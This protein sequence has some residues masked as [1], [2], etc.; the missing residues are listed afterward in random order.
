MV[1]SGPY[2][3]MVSMRHVGERYEAPYEVLKHIKGAVNGRLDTIQ[4]GARDKR[5]QINLTW[6]PVCEIT[7]LSLSGGPSVSGGS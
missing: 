5:G 7:S 1:P 4:P 2:L 6:L 3:H